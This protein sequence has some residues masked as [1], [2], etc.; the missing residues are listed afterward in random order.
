MKSNTKKWLT[1]MILAMAGSAIYRLPYLRETYYVPLQQATGAT[2][3][4]L[5]MLMGAYGLANF[6]LYFPGGW[7]ADRFSPRKL[8][9]FSCVATG[10]VGFYFATLPSF[11]MLVAIHAIWAI[12]TVFTFWPVAIRIIRLLGESKE[13][14]RLFGLWHFGKGLT[15]TILGFV[16]VP[17]FAKL[18]E[19]VMG[20]KGT[21]IFYSV[22]IIVV[23]ILAYF[24]LEDGKTAEESSKLVIKDMLQVLKCL[25][26]GLQVS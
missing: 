14:G 26:F 23:G 21:I 9:T 15:S 17:I 4:Q 22:T 18:G 7:A 8:I 5:G 25:L 24:I 12:T 1:L 10:L 11:P 13:Q 3:A 2:N 6:I 16:S 20:L 19:G